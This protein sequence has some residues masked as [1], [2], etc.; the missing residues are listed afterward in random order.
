VRARARAR[1]IRHTDH[2]APLS[3]EFATNFA[4]KHRSLGIVRSRTQATEF[5]FRNMRFLA[6]L[7]SSLALVLYIQVDPIML[8]LS[9]TLAKMFRSFLNPSTQMQG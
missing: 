3:T 8:T 4:D 1:A 2:A 5:S 9:G 6:T 7:K